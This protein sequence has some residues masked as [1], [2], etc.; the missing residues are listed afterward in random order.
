MQF[1]IIG[2]QT[3][4]LGAGG[5]GGPA[6]TKA[7]DMV[8]AKCYISAALASPN[9]KKFLMVSYIAVRLSFMINPTG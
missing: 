1:W 7:I 4:P 5:K 2:S 6:R 3:C 9:V 8:A